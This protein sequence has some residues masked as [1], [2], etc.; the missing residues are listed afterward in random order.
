MN[1]AAFS[2]IILLCR[3]GDRGDQISDFTG[4]SKTN[5]YAAFAFLI[6]FMSLAGIPPTAGFVAKLYLFAAAIET[7]YIWL[8]IIGLLNTIFAIYY[9]FRVVMWMY[10]KEPEGEIKLAPSSPMLKLAIAVM[11]IAIIVIGVNPGPF[12]DAAKASILPFL[13]SGKMLAAM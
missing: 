11:V 8:A 7:N 4:I 6:I 12:I 10:M 2:M 3:E 5:P 1:I 13:E 9:Y